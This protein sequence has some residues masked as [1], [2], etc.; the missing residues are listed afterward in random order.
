MLTFGRKWLEPV[1]CCLAPQHLSY[2]WP[3]LGFTE[4]LYGKSKGIKLDSKLLKS[5]GYY[6][7]LQ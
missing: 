1:F 2:L 5:K 3:L 6:S 4:Y 7:Y